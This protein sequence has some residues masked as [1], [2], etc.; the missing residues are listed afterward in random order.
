MYRTIVVG[1]DGSERA[2]RAVEHAAELAKACGAKLHLIHAYQ[3]V[4]SNIA[5]AMAAGAVA[6]TPPDLSAIANEEA[7]LAQRAL[8]EQAAKLTAEGVDTEAH[9]VAGSAVEVLLDQAAK[10]GADVIVTGNRGMT[11]AKR[12]L[13]SVP[14]T[15]AHHAE[16]AVLIVPTDV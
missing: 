16:C 13:G 6:A 11:G 4:D 3:G 10:L 9:A 12:I 5:R 8:D 15:V 1:T 14:N 7:S 2:E